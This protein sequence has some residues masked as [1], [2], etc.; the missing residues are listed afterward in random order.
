MMKNILFLFSVLISTHFVAQDSLFLSLSDAIKI[1]LKQN[2]DIQISKK[3]VEAN[4]LLNTWGEA[5][6]LPTINLSGSQD[7]TLS[8]QSKNPTSFIQE[9][10]Q[11]NSYNGGIALNWTIFNGFNVKANKIRLE[12]LVVQSEGTVSL[13]VENTIHGIILS[14]YQC[15]IQREQL[16]LLK[17][18]LE[19]SK[20]KFELQQTKNNLG[21]GVT[22]DLLQFESAYLTDSSNLILQE[23]VYKNAIRNLNVLLGVDVE[24]NWNLTDELTPPMNIYYF[25]DLNQKMLSNNTNIKNQLINFSLLKQDIEMAKS[26]FYPSLTFNSGGNYSNSRFAIGNL[27]ENGTSINYYGNFTLNFRLYDG[28]KVRRGIKAL[29]IQEEVNYLEMEKLKNE[30][31]QDL[32]INFDTYQTRLRIFDLN[33]RSFQVAQQNFDIAKIKEN[34]GLMS[35]FNLRDIE[36]AYLN[37]GISL[38]QST[39]NLIESNTTL[40]KL[41]GGI[42]QDYSE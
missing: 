6:M 29:K 18:V 34:S 10:L 35:S 26:S 24:R 27:S 4:E 30:L 21:L 33:K 25:D 31:S 40:L 20:E 3:Y 9:L 15:K 36:M 17:N 1:G 28:G 11:S 7:N 38:F 39:Y 19:L 37:S 5:G 22:V 8:D 42:I 32:A 14:Y 12:Q 13:A 23:L 2:Y 16:S 41:T